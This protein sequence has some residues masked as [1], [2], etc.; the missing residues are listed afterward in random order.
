MMTDRME[1]TAEELEQVT[2][3]NFWPNVYSE[4]EYASVGITVVNHIIAFDEF[5]WKGK[6]IGSSD[7][8]AVVNFYKEKG[9]VPESVEEAHTVVKYYHTDGGNII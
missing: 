7:A 4:S 9:R 3:G 8:N 1:I 2:G 6:D 5:W